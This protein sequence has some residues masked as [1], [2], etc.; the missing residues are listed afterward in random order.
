M[1]IYIAS[2]HAGFELKRDLILYLSGEGFDVQDCGP[3][4][5]DHEDDYPDFVS[6][7]AKNVSD[8]PDSRGLV[9]GYS[10]Q[11]ESVVA[12]RFPRVRCAVFYGGPK[13]VLTLSRE[14]NDANMLSLGANFLPMQ[15]AKEAVML[16]LQTNFS[17]EARHIRRINKI[18]RL[19]VEKGSKPK[20]FEI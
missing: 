11:G 15:E 17:N 12:N 14:H 1:R 8:D 13:H 6:I 18:N 19:N 2:D 20:E 9:M 7:A 16:W 3:V 4:T 10:G 5:Y